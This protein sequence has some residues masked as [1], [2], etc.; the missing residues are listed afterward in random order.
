MLEEIPVSIYRGG[1]SK[2][3]FI[4]EKVLP[5]DKDARDKILLKLMGS[6]DIRQIN[7]LGGA[8]ST[9][10]KAA[11]ISKEEKEDWDVNYTFAQVAVDKPVV[12]YSGNCGNISSAVGIYA[13]ENQ[14]VKTSSPTTMV[15]VYNTNTKKVI[16][17]YI[18]TPDG[19]LTYEGDFAI[20]G[21]PGKGIKIELQFVE[22]SGAFSGKLLPTGNTKDTLV[23]SN[24]QELTVSLVDAANPLVYVRAEDLGL[25][26]TESPEMIDS[27]PELLARLEEIR[28]RAAQLMGLIDKLED[29]AVIT[30]GVPKLTIVSAPQT[31]VTTENEKIEAADFDLAVRMMSMQKAHKSIALTGALCTGAAS[32]I[33]G[34]IPY[35]LVSDKNLG[36]Q[37]EIAHSSGKISVSI[38]YETTNDKTLIKSVS[39]YRTARKI[40]VGTAFIEEDRPC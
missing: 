28:G 11:I 35:E 27:D 25:E 31:Y 1:T 39:S 5:A 24:G 37:L 23:L 33:Q 3:V 12:S 30:P 29:S 18:P 20:S 38:D 19:K 17:E 36:N 4:D 7:G 22:P 34:T 32:K 2:G 15:R 10:S 13:I 26:G 14:L 6:P 16:N 8:V 9:T 40:M 21:V